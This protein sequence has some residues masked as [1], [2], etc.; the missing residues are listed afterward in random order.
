MY[1]VHLNTHLLKVRHIVNVHAKMCRF[2]AKCF[3]WCKC[4]F[5]KTRHLYI[6]SNMLTNYAEPAKKDGVYM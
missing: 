6:K 1:V 3:C 2:M 5:T 4:K